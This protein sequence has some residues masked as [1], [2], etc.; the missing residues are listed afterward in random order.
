M[1]D[2]GEKRLTPTQIPISRGLD[3]E[4]M[5]MLESQTQDSVHGRAISSTNAEEIQNVPIFSYRRVKN[6]NLKILYVTGKKK[7]GM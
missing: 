4:M 6:C 3:D 5:T 7:Q 2:G 1:Q